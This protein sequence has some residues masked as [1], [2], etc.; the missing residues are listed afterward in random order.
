MLN[1][2]SPDVR[3][4]SFLDV[5]REILSFTLG[6]E[7]EIRLLIYLDSPV[8]GEVGPEQNRLGQS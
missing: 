5:R 4:C 7:C 6:E 2:Q 1:D 3:G 8:K